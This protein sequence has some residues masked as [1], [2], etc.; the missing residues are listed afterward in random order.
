MKALFLLLLPSLA[1]SSNNT[2][3]YYRCTGKVG[4]EWNFG[5]APNACNASE[6]GSDSV[7]R[8]TYGALVFQDSASRTAERRRYMEDLH[9]VI[10]DA[11]AYYIKKRKP[12]ASAAEVAAFQLGMLATANQESYWS[13]YRFASDSRYKMMRGDV[14]HGHG[15]MQLDDRAHFP[16][17]ENGTAWNLM[18]NIA[19]SM[20]E[21]FANW[22]KASAQNCVGSATNWE[23]RTRAAWAAY[24]G[25]PSKLCRWTNPN[26]KWANNDKGFY[27]KLKNKSW[28][29]YV[30]D[31]DSLAPIN[32]PCLIEKRE[33]CPAPGEPENQPIRENTL[34]RTA[35]GKACVLIGG[36]L[37]CLDE[38]RDSVCLQAV[39]R[40][41]NTNAIVVTDEALSPYPQTSLDRHTTCAA[42]E[43]SLIGVGKMAEAVTAINL[44]ATPGGG[45]VGLVPKGEVVEVLDFEIRNLATRDRYYKVSIDGVTGFVYAGDA[46]DHANWLVASAKAPIPAVVAR[47]GEKVGIV[48]SAGINLR[49][50]PGG[51]L[52][53]NIPAHTQMV[54]IDYLVRND[55]NDLYYRVNY[56]GKTGYIYSG[57]LLPRDTTLLWTKR[58]K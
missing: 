31:D 39:S 29:G 19:Y 54:V 24:N 16:A 9:A 37:D 12:G 5:R 8:D 49:S 32:V 58:I 56:G 44:R 51:A 3:D 28:E 50:A 23:A 57:A 30:S 7:V 10:R 18:G 48:N 4:G 20:D 33:N 6:F 42:F 45:L 41:T 40:F 11:A 26:D 17:V 21:F 15:L 47:P 46:S 2:P 35:A 22:E 52:I 55:V 38:F 1:L 25:G 14:G 43:P 36:A 53:R 27:E 13:H 34:Y